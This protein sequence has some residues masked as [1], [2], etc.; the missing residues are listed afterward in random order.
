MPAVAWL[1]CSDHNVRRAIIAFFSSRFNFTTWQSLMGKGDIT[2]LVCGKLLLCPFDDSCSG[3]YAD[4]R[5]SRGVVPTER[6][7]AVQRPLSILAQ[8]TALVDLDV[9]KSL[10]V[11]PPRSTHI[12]LPSLF[13]P[14]SHPDTPQFPSS[15]PTLTC[16]ITHPPSPSSGLSILSL[17]LVPICTLHYL[18]PL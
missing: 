16:P 1:T 12:A 2:I 7:E 10:S 4:G 13:A 14:R 5:R 17:R 15:S 6:T 18:L 11:L 8:I 3:M 9:H